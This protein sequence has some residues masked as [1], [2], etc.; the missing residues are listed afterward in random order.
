[1]KTTLTHLRDA[2]S[3]KAKGAIVLVPFRG[4]IYR[5]ADFHPV[6]DPMQI[7]CKLEL[8]GQYRKEKIWANTEGIIVV[9]GD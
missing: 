8:N 7:V 4:E 9:T 2:T 5:L 1:M 3:K 6:T